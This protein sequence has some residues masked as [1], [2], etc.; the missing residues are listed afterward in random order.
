MTAEELQIW[1]E[2]HIDEIFSFMDYEPTI[3]SEEEL[4]GTL[5]YWFDRED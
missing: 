4:A 1:L 3:E 2:E 5:R